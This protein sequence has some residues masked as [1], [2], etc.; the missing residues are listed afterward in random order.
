MLDKNDGSPLCTVGEIYSFMK[1]SISRKSLS[2]KSG[3]ARIG[4]DTRLPHGLANSNK[5]AQRFRFSFEMSKYEG[6]QKHLLYFDLVILAVLSRSFFESR[7]HEAVS[8]R[9]A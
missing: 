6:Q 1:M 2:K 3:Q 9:L 8:K 4:T 5:T 7:G